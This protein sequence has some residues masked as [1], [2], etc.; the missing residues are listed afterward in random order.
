MSYRIASTALLAVFLA[1]GPASA[2]GFEPLN[3]GTAPPSSETAPAGGD[4][5]TAPPPGG[6]SQGTQSPGAESSGVQSPG[7]SIFVPAPSAEAPDAGNIFRDPNG[8]FTA[9]I[10][11]GWTT[12]L[13]GDGSV[14]F[15]QGD[16]WVVLATVQ[17]TDPTAGAKVVI[18]QMGPAYKL[19]Q[20]NSAT[21]TISG[22]PV[23]YAVFKGQSESQGPV[24]MM[25]AGIQAPSGHVLAFISSAPLADI[26]KVSPAF[27]SIMQGIRFA[28][29]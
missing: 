19:V 1:A 17:P 26:T 5:T 29:E 28:G 11:A 10:P 4:Q 22:H 27:L 6:Q 8:N 15:L 12:S 24:A 2:Q 25:I 21:A 3:P 13:P 23:Y 9:P 16:A 14:Q 7:A 20:T 18:D